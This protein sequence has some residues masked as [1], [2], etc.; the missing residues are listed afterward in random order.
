MIHLLKA[1]L[2]LSCILAGFNIYASKN[3]YDK[4]HW[5]K[6]HGNVK[7]HWAGNP[8]SGV[9]CKNNICQREARFS[10]EY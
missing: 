6:A 9:H 7:G 8:N 5:V 4:A 1:I 10:W 2:L 3:P